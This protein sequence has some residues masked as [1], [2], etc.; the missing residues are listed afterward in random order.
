MIREAARLS[1]KTERR[2]LRE[3]AGHSAVVNRCARI[4]GDASID[5]ASRLSRTR[6][7]LDPGAVYAVIRALV[8]EH[9][10]VPEARG[11]RPPSAPRDPAA[12][13]AVQ[14]LRAAIAGNR[15][16]L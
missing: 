14:A 4:T 11:S 2:V 16:G 5:I 12:L 10:C 7:H 15:H 9:A 8:D 3:V 6:R 13:R 1:G